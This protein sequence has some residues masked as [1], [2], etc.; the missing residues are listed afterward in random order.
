MTFK[1]ISGNV[2]KIRRNS[3]LILL[4]FF[5]PLNYMYTYFTDTY[6]VSYKVSAVDGIC[7]E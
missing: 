5:F 6:T 2:L 3:H 4:R 1:I 7:P